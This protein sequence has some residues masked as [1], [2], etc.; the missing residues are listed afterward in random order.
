VRVKGIR[1]TGSEIEVEWD[2]EIG[3]DDL[4]WTVI[5]PNYLHEY[6]DGELELKTH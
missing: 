4:A 6:E 2:A 1:F 5:Q 3:D